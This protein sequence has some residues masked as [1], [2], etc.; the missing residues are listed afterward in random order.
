MKLLRWTILVV[1]ATILL[2]FALGFAFLAVTM[3]RMGGIPWSCDFVQF[4][5]GWA[6]ILLC[7]LGLVG[8]AAYMFARA[9]NHSI[10]N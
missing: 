3:Q 10:S 7:G 9:R 8:L 6:L 4:N 5:I 2:L 1:G